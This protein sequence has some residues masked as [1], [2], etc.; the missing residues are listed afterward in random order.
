MIRPRTARVRRPPGT[1]LS[2][3]ENATVVVVGGGPAGSFF[4]IRLLRKTRQA[5]RA[6][7]VIILEKK[8][9]VCFYTPLPFSSWEGCNYCAGGVS[10]RLVDGLRREKIFLPEE[11]IESRSTEVVIHGDW[12]SILLAVPE[13][14]EM[15]SVFR[16]SRP[17]Q[18]AGRYVNFDTFLLHLAAD[19]GAQVITAEVDD[20]RYSPEGKPLIDYRETMGDVAYCGNGEPDSGCAKP[21]VTPDTTPG[22]TLDTAPG[23]APSASQGNGTIE[24]D[25]AVFAGGVNR[26]P[27]MDMRDDPL[28]TALQKMIPRLRPPKVRKAV[29]AEMRDSQA[30][31]RLVE[32]EMHFVQYG[33]RDLR[34]EMASVMPKK[35]WITVVLL[36]KSVD[37]AQPTASLDLVERFL[38]LPNIRRL[39]PR[40]AE[41]VARC[42][43]NPNMTVGAARNPFGERVALTG[44]L[45]V[46]RLYKDGLYSAFTTSSALADCVLDEGIDETS[47][48][49]HYGP[50][51]RRLHADNRYGRVIFWLSHWVL[52][53][54]ASSRVLYRAVITERM[55]T[56][57][58]RRRLA[59]V[60]WQVASGDE[61]YRR[62]LAGML[63]PAS[64]WLI[65]T[66]GLLLTLRDI[67][68]ETLFGLDWTGVPRYGTGV[69]VEQVEETRN[70]LFAVQGV[71]PPPRAPQME[72]MFTVRI[73]AGKKAILKQLGA[74]G[75]PDREYL[76]PRFVRIHRVTGE[77]N[78]VGTV[79]RYSIPMLRL[80][81]SVGLESV[82]PD[83]YLLYRIVEGMGEGGIL[84]FLL[85]ELRPGVSLLTI[86]VGFDFPRGRG[87]G[88]I[89]W[90]MG[91]RLFPEFA[92][93]VVWNHSLCQIRHLAEVEEG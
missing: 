16:G 23:T 72:S 6:V 70:A 19:E 80:S 83:R 64:L 58:H 48:A 42:C 85:D 28:L 11:V 86:Y 4:A 40:K 25:F 74:F 24:A 77:P 22:I 14:R 10:P 29:I 67:V 2:L 91:R 79:I 53:H 75:D 88:R 66:G 41:L 39:V 32:G 33:S 59:P 44:D 52:A 76:K 20:V 87:L 30:R 5:G 90:A 61:V 47:L 93:D 15:L 57:Q 21:G 84:A 55:T 3:P 65:L 82:V 81:F 54:P 49:K 89:G 27:G 37:R 8:R 73:R 46:A 9:E 34:I 1:P 71:E 13:G 60:L 50:V 35:D 18:R 17:R 43:C 69:P 56:P 63:H 78:Q 38:E 92:H 62:A 7:K 51:V 31:V 12:K 26:R 68:T 36:G 45:A